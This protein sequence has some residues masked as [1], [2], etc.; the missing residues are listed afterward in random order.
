MFQSDIDGGFGGAIQDGFGA[1]LGSVSSQLTGGTKAE[2][3]T[4]QSQP[5]NISGQPPAGVTKNIRS[6]VSNP[7]TLLIAGGAIM[8][9]AVLFLAVK[10]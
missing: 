5:E 4:D 2:K 7:K 6:A 1:F 3:V 8:V 9:T 10:K